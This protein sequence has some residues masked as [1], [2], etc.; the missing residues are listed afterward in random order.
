VHSDPDYAWITRLDDAGA[1]QWSIDDDTVYRF[2]EVF[3]SSLGRSITRGEGVGT[4]IVIK[5]HSAEGDLVS[6][7]LGPKNSELGGMAV[8]ASGWIYVSMRVMGED[9]FVQKYDPAG[10]LI[11]TR[12]LES[13]AAVPVTPSTLVLNPARETLGVVCFE[14]GGIPYF[15]E[16]STSGEA[17]RPIEL[18]ADWVEAADPGGGWLA[19]LYSSN[20]GDAV[21]RYS[22]DFTLLWEF[23]AA[24]ET[25]SDIAADA[26]GN[27]YAAGWD[28]QG[29]GVIRKL[30]P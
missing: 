3:V 30:V 14:L 20:G 26:I 9:V 4:Q 25:I 23:E 2:K 16:L 6:D 8:D 5:Q 7:I 22:H 13:K 1:L 24:S 28:E 10:T 15:A 29:N 19:G 21:R 18:A 12:L 11:W 17:L 27:V